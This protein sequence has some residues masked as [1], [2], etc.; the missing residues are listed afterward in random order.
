MMIYLLKERRWLRRNS[1]LKMREFVT[2]LL[3]VI[4]LLIQVVEQQK[5]EK[6]L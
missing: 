1:L 5:K 2:Y 3:S 4:T 6:E